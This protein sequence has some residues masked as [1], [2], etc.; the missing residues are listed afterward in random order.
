[1]AEY[2]LTGLRVLVVEDEA[3]VS[4]L[5]EDYLEELGCEVIGLA[6][7]LENGMENACTLP[8]DAAV[9]DVNL[10]GRLSYPVEQALHACGVPVVFTTGYSTEGLPAA[11]QNAAVPSKPFR[12]EQLAQALSDMQ[13]R[14]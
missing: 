3:M 8:L 5:V 2:G 13:T 4:M 10:A 12:P 7:R 9:L 6:S 11:L 1:M 14:F